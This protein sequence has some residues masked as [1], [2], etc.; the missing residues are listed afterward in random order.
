MYVQVSEYS[1][2]SFWIGW[3]DGVISVGSGAVFTHTL[4]TWIDEDPIVPILYASV[5]S[6]HNSPGE[7]EL[8]HSEGFIF[9]HSL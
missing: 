1:M 9:H 2:R 7:W 8:A 5:S 3:E 4:L 6:W